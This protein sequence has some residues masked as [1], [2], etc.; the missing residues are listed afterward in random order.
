MELTFKFFPVSFGLGKQYRKNSNFNKRAWVWNNKTK[1]LKAYFKSDCIG[2]EVK[3][4]LFN[5]PT[6]E[7]IYM[8][9]N[10]LTIGH[11][12]DSDGKGTPVNGI[13]SHYRMSID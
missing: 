9:M 3:E 11:N 1:I 10:T 12:I 5:V 8:I 6:I 2:G 7:D 4:Y 13:L